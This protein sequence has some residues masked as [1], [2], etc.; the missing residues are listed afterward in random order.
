MPAARNGFD[1]RLTRIAGVRHWRSNDKYL[2][3]QNEEKGE[4]DHAY[5]R[6][7]RQFVSPSLEGPPNDLHGSTFVLRKSGD[8][9]DNQFR[10]CK[11]FRERLEA[12]RGS[13][14]PPWANA[15]W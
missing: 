11:P 1:R 9:A 8:R 6:C 3:Y 5:D 7:T 13:D 4:C 12:G 2:W 10:S 15:A 14:G